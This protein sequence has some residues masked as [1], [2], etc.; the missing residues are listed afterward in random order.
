MN[1]KIRLTLIKR[2]PTDSMTSV[3]VLPEGGMFLRGHGDADFMCGACDYVL[4]EAID[5]EH[6]DITG[7]VIRCP[8]CG[9]H[10]DTTG[11]GNQAR[12]NLS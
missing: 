5:T 7:I 6:V 3:I 12:P 2:P 1:K 4:A 9:R 10:N 11:S 8:R